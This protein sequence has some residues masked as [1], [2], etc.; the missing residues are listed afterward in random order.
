MARKGGGGGVGSSIS[1][2]PWRVDHAPCLLCSLYTSGSLAFL[3]E[4]VTAGVDDI[5][6]I[7]SDVLSLVT[8][9]AEATVWG[10]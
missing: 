6:A 2:T 5:P 10:A 8:A 9:S 1:L 7:G 4:T 3:A